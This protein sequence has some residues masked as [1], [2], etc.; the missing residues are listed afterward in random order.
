MPIYLNASPLNVFPELERVYKPAYD[1][2]E[3]DVTVAG[4]C[5]VIEKLFH[6]DPT[7]L[8]M[9]VLFK[10]FDINGEAL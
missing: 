10:E 8:A 6:E 5:E 4:L 7:R 2:T 1:L 3:G 9:D